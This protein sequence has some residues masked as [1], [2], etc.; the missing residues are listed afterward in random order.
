MLTPVAVKLKPVPEHTGFVED[1]METVGINELVTDAVIPELV[2][3]PMIQL[4]PAPPGTN[5]ASTTSLLFA[6]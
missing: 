1:A 6:V 3:E 4:D 5:V 2:A